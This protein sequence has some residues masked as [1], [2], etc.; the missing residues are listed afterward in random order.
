MSA[1]SHQRLVK[2]IADKT[3]TTL[4][5]K[6]WHVVCASSSIAFGLALFLSSEIANRVKDSP[7]Y[8]EK[9][10]T[11]L[12]LSDSE[13]ALKY[14]IIGASASSCLVQ[15]FHCGVAFFKPTLK[16]T[17]SAY[18][19]AFMIMLISFTSEVIMMTGN[20][21]SVCEDPF[22]VK[23]PIIQISEWQITVPLMLY[24]TL[25][26]DTNKKKLTSRDYT[27]LL[28]GYFGVMCGFLP[29]LLS[30]QMGVYALIVAACAVPY[31]LIMNVVDAY[32]SY[33]KTIAIGM[34]SPSEYVAFT[35][36]RRRLETSIYLLIICLFFPATFFSRA[37]G[38]VGS[39]FVFAAFAIL[40][41]WSKNLFA[42]FLMEG[43]L[44]VLDPSVYQLLAEKA[45]NATKRAFIRYVFHEVLF[46]HA[47]RKCLSF[48][49]QY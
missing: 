13:I 10:C 35:I 3:P 7:S 15:V 27:I 42:M 20:F 46:F 48:F 6:Q 23:S 31:A 34:A 22:G 38:L 40:N 30:W 1:T 44:E 33:A 39:N 12:V 18:M 43:H 29:I 47:T 9:T 37:F 21:D 14:M 41:F 5:S 19:T 25:T 26:L 32:S 28:C 4:V 45:A 36:S 16:N 2:K 11:S 49:D 8:A 17:F 24:L